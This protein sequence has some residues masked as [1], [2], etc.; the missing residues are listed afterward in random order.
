MKNEKKS[1]KGKT[2]ICEKAKFVTLD[3]RTMKLIWPELEDTVI[4][5]IKEA[6][7][8][9]AKNKISMGSYFVCEPWSKNPDEIDWLN[10]R[11]KLIKDLHSNI[12]DCFNYG[13]DGFGAMIDVVEGYSELI[14]V[15]ANPLKDGAMKKAMDVFYKKDGIK[16]PII[17]SRDLPNTWRI[18]KKVSED[19]EDETE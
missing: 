13:F 10:R 14:S 6:I 3:E 18:D 5:L 8:I 17:D 2:K 15:L 9:R 19:E 7:A 1:K 16:I 12:A 4:G 11:T